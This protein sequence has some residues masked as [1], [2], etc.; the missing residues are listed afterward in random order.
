MSTLPDP[1]QLTLDGAPDAPP[2]SLRAG[3]AVVAGKSSA[4]GRPSK[5]VRRD[6]H[7]PTRRMEV[8]RWL[9]VVAP[10]DWSAKVSGHSWCRCGY[11]RTAIGR[12]AVQQLVQDH[13][14]HRAHCPLLDGGEGSLAA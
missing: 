7:T 14:D 4:A 2:A 11:D 13:T 12:A 9:R 8:V 6:P 10:P 5:P 3:R 1:A